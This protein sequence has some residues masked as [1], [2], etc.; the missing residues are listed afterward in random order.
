MITTDDLARKLLARLEE[1][2]MEWESIEGEST[3]STAQ[4]NADDFADI[5]W[6]TLSEFCPN[7]IRRVEMPDGGDGYEVT[8]R[9]LPNAWRL[10]GC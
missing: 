9:P 4:K 6:V 2:Q 8:D 3:L 1:L 5:V 7:V 10:F